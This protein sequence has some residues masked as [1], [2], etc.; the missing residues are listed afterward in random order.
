MKI[1]SIF[2]SLVFLAAAALA[3]GGAGQTSVTGCLSGDPGSY[4]LIEQS[5]G[6]ALEV[7]GS[8]VDLKPHLGHEV[9]LIA[10]VTGSGS[11]RSIQVKQLKMISEHCP[12]AKVMG[13]DTSTTAAATGSSAPAMIASN[14]EPSSTDAPAA[15]HKKRA[16]PKTASPLPLLGAM[17]LALLCVGFFGLRR[18]L[19]SR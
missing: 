3:Q 4:K 18:K 19:Y 16:M 5:T 2:T 1:V 7:A 9:E 10:Q 8:A 6:A 12:V 15:P 13:T 11:A 14:A 17:G